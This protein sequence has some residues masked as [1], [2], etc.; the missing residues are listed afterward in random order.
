MADR[1]QLSTGVDELDK[2]LGGGY[3]RGES[4]L[5]EHDGPNRGEPDG[6]GAIAGARRDELQGC[7]GGDRRFGVVWRGVVGS[8]GG[9]QAGTA[10]ETDRC[11]GC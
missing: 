8:A 3:F 6:L 1:E 10:T 11:D 7:G 5:L 4:V 2:L 9:Q